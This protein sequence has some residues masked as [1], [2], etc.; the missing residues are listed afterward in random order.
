[1]TVHQYDSSTT[2][3]K[4]LLRRRCTAPSTAPRRTTARRR[5]RSIPSDVAHTFTIHQYPR[6]LAAQLLRQRPDARGGRQ[7]PERGQRLPQ[8]PMTSRSPSSPASP[9]EYVWNCE[10]PCGD[11]YVDFGG[12]DER[13]RLDE[14]NGHGGLMS[15]LTTR[16]RRRSTSP[17]SRPTDPDPIMQ[18]REWLSRA[19]RAA[20]HRLIILFVL[21]IVIPL[22][23]LVI[24]FM[25]LS[26]APASPIMVEIERT[27]FVFTLVSAPLMAVTLAILVYSLVGW[28]RV[29][30]EEP[31]MQESPAIR[32]NGRAIVLW[33]AV[34]SL[35]AAFLVVW[36]LVELATI[37]AYAIRLDAGQPAAQRR[38]SPS[39]STSPASSGSGRSS[40]PTRAGLPRRRARRADQRAAV[41]QRDVE[42]RRA[43]L[44]GRRARASRSTPIPGAIT[45]TG[46]TPDKLGTFNIRCAELCGLHHAYMETQIKVVTQDAVRRLGP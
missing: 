40:T 6:V 28:G 18:L 25:N 21:T 37:T 41:L 12:V 8:A 31:P 23:W 9:G 35:L 2:V 43:Q 46:V 33:I 4:R 3:W 1:M 5:Q 24:H 34:T 7:R 39:T 14:R 44:L 11:G 36:G 19:L 29:T 26:G 17:R 32:T 15:T 38:R 30:G 16:R 10:D 20:H 45:N 22:A 27:M 42:R 13:A